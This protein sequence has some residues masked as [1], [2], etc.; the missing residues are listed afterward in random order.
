MPEIHVVVL[1]A[2]KGTR[3]KSAVPKVLHQAAELSLIDRTL[4]A[5]AFLSP[6]SITVVVGHQASLIK[7][8]LAGQPGLSF[9]AQ[10][11]Q[12]G[13]GHALLQVE[14]LK[15]YRAGEIISNSFVESA[16]NQVISKRMVKK[17]QMRWSPRG[18]HLLLQIRTR[19]LNDTLTDDY[20]RW[21]PG[22]THTD[23]QDQTA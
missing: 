20:R 2:G 12:L 23:R 8:A 16:V 10:E 18:A 1:A 6:A 17:Q 13:T 5:A 14:L 15:R 22:F 11:P 19:V 4:R 9:A 21:Y 7:E 3:M